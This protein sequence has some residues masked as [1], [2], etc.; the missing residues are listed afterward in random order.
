[1]NTKFYLLL[2]IVFVVS[3]N[4][5]VF[6]QGKDANSAEI[7]GHY[8]ESLSWLQSVSME[9][10]TKITQKGH[11]GKM[12]YHERNFVFRRDGSRIEC[13]GQVLVFDDKGDVNLPQSFDFKEVM[14]G[15]RSLSVRNS[16]DKPPVSANISGHYEDYQKRVLDSPNYGGPLGGKIFGNNRKSVAELLGESA[17]LHLRDEQEN[18]NGVSYYVLEGTTKYGEVTAWIAPQKGY[19]A[20]KWT[21]HKTGDDL[22]HERPISSNSWLAV[23]D[24]VELQKVG[25]VFVAKDGN[26]TLTIDHSD[27][28]TTVLRYE[29]KISNIQLNPDFEALGA[30]KVDLPNGTRVF[31]EESPGVRYVWQNGKIVPDVDAPTFEEIDKTIDEL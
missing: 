18:I 14:T 24:S 23:F 21:I 10:D 31:V 26:F 19:S 22:F 25:D 12:P 11:Q 28:R 30:F 16:I 5:C 2:A 29:Y 20:L 9:I 7:L 17:N 4:V 13:R 6:G 15:L 8:E 3:S 27:G 1:M